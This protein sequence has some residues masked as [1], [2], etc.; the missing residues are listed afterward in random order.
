MIEIF[1]K[2]VRPYVISV[3]KWKFNVDGLSEFS[4]D[5]LLILCKYYK[6]HKVKKN[7]CDLSNWR[8]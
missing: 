7:S 1:A 4:D 5:Y 6:N 3:W 2:A 8:S